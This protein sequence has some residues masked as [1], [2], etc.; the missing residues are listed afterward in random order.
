[1]SDRRCVYDA[2]RC[3]EN[4]AMQRCDID[5]DVFAQRKVQTFILNKS[6]KLFQLL[7]ISGFSDIEPHPND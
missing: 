3:I 7:R 4:D 6:R 2:S 1:M 5:N